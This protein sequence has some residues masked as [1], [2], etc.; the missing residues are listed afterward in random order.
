MNLSGWPAR[1]ADGRFAQAGTATGQGAGRPV[2]RGVGQPIRTLLAPV[3]GAVAAKHG[4]IVLAADAD[5][6]CQQYAPN[7]VSAALLA[8]QNVGSSSSVRSAPVAARSAQIDFTS[9][10][11]TVTRK[12][13]TCEP[14]SP[15]APARPLWLGSMRHAACLLPVSFIAVTRQPWCTQRS[16]CAPYRSPCCAPFCASAAPTACRTPRRN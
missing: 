2:Q 14:M 11:V 7:R 4:Q 13:L 5:L 8:Q 12:F 10:P 15:M 1:C 16:S 6:R 3:Q 9:S